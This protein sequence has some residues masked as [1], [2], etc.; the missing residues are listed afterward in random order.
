MEAYA[1]NG[2]MTTPNRKERV[3]LA[4]ML[5]GENT[6]AGLTLPEVRRAISQAP[7]S[8]KTWET[9]PDRAPRQYRL[10][11]VLADICVRFLLWEGSE[12][13][14]ERGPH[15]SYAELEEETGHTKRQLQTARKNGDAEGLPW[16]TRGTG[17]DVRAMSVNVPCTG[18]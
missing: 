9:R 17:R 15:K 7:R 2:E 14:P 5:R 12:W 6:I 1:E 3:R 16:R 18:G 4:D 10:G 11:P 13:D 8:R